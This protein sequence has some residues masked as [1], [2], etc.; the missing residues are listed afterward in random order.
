MVATRAV[1]IAVAVFKLLYTFGA[2]RSGGYPFMK[3]ILFNVFRERYMVVYGLLH[4]L[5]SV[6]L[7][8]AVSLINVCSVKWVWFGNKGWI[9]GAGY[10]RGRRLT[11]SGCVFAHSPASN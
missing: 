10:R 5:H 4:G 7:F 8:G 6:E 11:A 2:A 1:I 3:S 9:L